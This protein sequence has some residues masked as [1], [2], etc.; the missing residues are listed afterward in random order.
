MSITAEPAA[1]W[2]PWGDTPAPVMLTTGRPLDPT[3]DRGMPIYFRDI[4]KRAREALALTGPERFMLRRWLSG[5]CGCSYSDPQMMRLLFGL[6][7]VERTF[8]LIE[9]DTVVAPVGISDQWEPLRLKVLGLFPDDEP[10]QYVALCHSLGITPVTTIAF[11]E[12]PSG[13]SNLRCALLALCTSP[14][15]LCLSAT[16]SNSDWLTT[17]F[18]RHQ[19]DTV[20]I[21]LR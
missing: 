1:Q 19:A 10:R 17:A 2:P 15:S 3:I 11:D 16:G 20:S 12:V 7:R 13:E 5:Y 6:E 14:A 18:Q 8:Y 4:Q 9:H 21:L